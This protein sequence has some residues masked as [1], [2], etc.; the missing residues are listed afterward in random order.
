MQG[1]EVK[2]GTERAR[3]WRRSKDTASRPHAAEE[4]LH[5]VVDL[6]AQPADPALGDAGH[7]HC[8]HQI[9]HRKGRNALH[10]GLLHHGGER[11]LGRASRLQEAR[12][13]RAL[14]QLG[15]LRFDRAGTGLPDSVAL[16]V[17]LSQTLGVFSP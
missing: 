3:R 14:A 7:A 6:A 15:N 9:V 5:S 2:S 16:A 11:L 4:R 12:E 17:A 10:E 1:V 8:L 13:V